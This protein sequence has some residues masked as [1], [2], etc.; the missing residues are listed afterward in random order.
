MSGKRKR[1]AE[2]DA[3]GNDEPTF[4]EA[5]ERLEEIV[6][7]LEEGEVPLEQSLQAYAEGTRLVRTCLDRL[8][9]AENMIRELG[10]GADGFRLKGTPLQDEVRSEDGEA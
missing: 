2:P 7:R 8:E 4:E 6:S 10:E 3:A 1:G 9:R 5:L